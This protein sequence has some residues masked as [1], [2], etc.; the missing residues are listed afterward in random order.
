MPLHRKMFVV[1]PYLNEDRDSKSIVFLSW[2]YHQGLGQWFE[3]YT[4]DVAV[5]RFWYE[6][7]SQAT[8]TFD[9]CACD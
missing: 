5:D 4:V 3:I 1:P 6:D 2:T 7:I 9:G 8:W